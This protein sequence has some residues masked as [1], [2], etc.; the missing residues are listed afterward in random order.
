M[1]QLLEAVNCHTTLKIATIMILNF[2]FRI[3][4]ITNLKVQNIDFTKEIITIHLG[5]G[6]KTRR[7]TILDYQKPILKRILRTRQG[8]L[9]I[10]SPEDHFLINKIT[11]RKTSINWLQNYYVRISKKL[12]FRVHAHRLRRTF[13][14][15]LFFDNRIDIYL[16]AWLLGHTSI[17]TTMRYL[18]IK[19]KQKHED[20]KESMRG[21]VIVPLI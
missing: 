3:S 2:G 1:N 15:I 10:N 5:K 20:Y 16:I 4:E 18:G 8:M 21:K 12:G 13:A 19:E 14:S 11:G 7:I 6:R 9:A 17:Q